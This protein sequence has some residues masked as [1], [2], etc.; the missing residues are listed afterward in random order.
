MQENDSC[1]TVIHMGYVQGS[2]KV[3]DTCVKTM[4]VGMM[5]RGFTALGCCCCCY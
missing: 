1:G 3:K 5:A 2:E 4:H